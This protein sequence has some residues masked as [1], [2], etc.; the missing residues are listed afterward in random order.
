MINEELTGATVLNND[1]FANMDEITISLI[2]DPTNGE[3][4]QNTDGTFTYM[5]NEDYFGMDEFTY[6]ICNVNCPDQCDQAVVTIRINIGDDC[7][8]PD[9]ITPNNDGT[10]DNFT[11]TCLRDPNAFPDN[12]MQIFNRW[13]DKVY[14]AT[15]YTNSWDG[16]WRNSA[17]P[18]GTYFYCLKLTPDSE[19]ETGYVT[20]I[21]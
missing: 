6:E 14:E 15:P 20:I 9:F 21:R 12:E 2:T 5:P 4:T 8:V 17:L 19:A 13:G 3:V 1:A 10:N 7:F 11:V 18:P 16:T